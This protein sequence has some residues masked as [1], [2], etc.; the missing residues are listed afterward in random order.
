MPPGAFQVVQGRE[1]VADRLIRSPRVRKVSLTG[2]V[3]TGRSVAALAGECLKPVTMELGG[4]SPLIILGDADVSEAARLAVLANFYSGGQVC[5]NGT[6]VFVPASLESEFLKNVVSL[7]QAIRL[8][9]PTDLTTEMG[10]L[11]NHAQR[12]KAEQAIA[13]GVREGARLLTGGRRPERFSKG[14]YLTPAVFAGVTDEMS[15]AREEIFG[16]VMSVLT[17]KDEA[18]VIARANQLEF[19][20]AAGVISRDVARAERLAEK[21]EAGVCWINTYNDTPL[22]LPFGGVK[23]SGFGRENGIHGLRQY[24][25]TKTILTSLQPVA[26]VFSGFAPPAG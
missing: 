2:S 9:D 16:P 14:A 26:P 21:L 20:L 5:T 7:T 22:H 11:I 8:G 4:K 6:R 12:D 25:Q 1:R 13:R 18:E 10:P 23:A 17:F 19:G 24:Q 3:A 15:L